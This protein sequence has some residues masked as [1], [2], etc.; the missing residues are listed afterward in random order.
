MWDRFDICAAHQ[1]LESEW[2]V[3]GI[4][5]ERPANRRRN[6]STAAQ[7][8][9]IGFPCWFSFATLEN[10]NQREIYVNAM[11][12][13]GLVPEQDSSIARWLKGDNL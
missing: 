7:L 6:E 1:A 9:R 10:D 8:H 2:H 12:S 11:Q 5:R 4:L 3:G 13:Y